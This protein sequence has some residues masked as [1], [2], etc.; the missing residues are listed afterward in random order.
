[1]EAGITHQAQQNPGSQRSRAGCLTCKRRRVKCD[2]GHPHCLR[3]LKANLRCEGY[4]RPRK[5]GSTAQRVRN[6]RSLLLPKLDGITPSTIR[7]T[8]ILPGETEVENR[9]MQY[10]RQ[11]TTSGFQ[12]AWDWTLWNRLMLQ[13]CHH[14]SYM[15][16]AVVAIGALHKSLRTWS[17][18]GQEPNT[19]NS[20]S[21]AK[22]HREFAYLTYGKALKRMQLV[23]DANLGPRHALIAC[24][25]VVCFET[26]T[27][28]RYKALK[29]AK[30]GLEILQEWM[31]QHKFCREDAS[32]KS[33]STTDVEDEIVEAF[34]S[35]DIQVS[36]I[37]DNRTVE[38]HEKFIENDSPIVKAIPNEFAS[39]DEAKGYW[40]VIMRRTYHFL[41]TTWR[42]TEPGALVREFETK[43]P[44]AV[45]VT[46]GDT[47]H[48]TS[49]KVDQTVRTSQ[50]RFSVEIACWL[51]TFMPLFSRM[52]RS[53]GF[54]L[55]DYVVATML[56]I[57]ALV[58]KITLAGVNFTQ[59]I[60]YDQFHA[61]FKDIIRYA[62]DVAKVRQSNPNLDFW[63]GSFQ[64]DL[65]L[66]EP[67]FTLLLRCR[68]PVLRRKAL[69]ILEA[70]HLECWWDPLL[71]IAIGRFIMEVEEEGMVEGFIPEE[72][73]AILTAKSH[74]PPQRAM[75]LQCVQRTGRPGGGLKW[76]ERF[77]SW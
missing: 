13:G 12:S 43:N 10:F 47:I 8:A 23:I 56:Q 3:C 1:M 58:T 69:A 17:T 9:Y 51:Q 7:L 54:T 39:L 65:G 75:V 30:H 44:G 16:Y 26:H 35:L 73:R 41:A 14:E 32:I 19:A 49:F 53:S 21:M 34:R 64:L 57:Q 50:L 77:V 66:V 6:A 29:H 71:I 2:E 68:D 31:N 52:R 24:L 70:W 18:N 60:C 72:S 76:T 20:E 5:N 63:A 22:L 55:R 15:R 28:N 11:E 45:L 62:G 61:N 27:G 42:R 59:E 74:C 33:P 38:V 25:L 37:S 4:P 48:T 36:T 46:V 67:L 40:N